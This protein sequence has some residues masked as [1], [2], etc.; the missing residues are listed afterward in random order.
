MWNYE[1]INSICNQFEIKNQQKLHIRRILSSKSRTDS[2]QPY[3]PYFLKTKLK[4]AVMLEEEKNKIDYEN[5]NL[6]IKVIK[7]KLKPSKYSQNPEDCPAFNKQRMYTKRIYKEIEKYKQN[8]KIYTKISK[9]H[10]NYETKKILKDSENYQ[11]ICER[12]KKKNKTMKTILN[13]QSPNYFK[14]LID[15][16]YLNQSVDN[17]YN[18][19]NINNYN[20]SYINSTI[21]SKNSGYEKNNDDN[22]KNNNTNKN[23]NSNKKNN[24]LKRSESCQNLFQ[25]KI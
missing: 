2:S 4:K 20:N 18:H 8:V 19:Y 24:K 3:K 6:L 15:N 22:N 17:F 23:T 14:K 5:Q 13:F 21:K 7:A 10:S 1:H 9:I 11:K 25:Q 16:Y 12:I